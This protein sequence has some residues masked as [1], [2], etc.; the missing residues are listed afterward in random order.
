M[1]YSLIQ[2][3]G[4]MQ[5]TPVWVGDLG[6]RPKDL[7]FKFRGHTPLYSISV[8]N[9]FFKETSL[10]PTPNW[11]RFDLRTCNSFICIT[12]GLMKVRPT[13]Y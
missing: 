6:T 3:Q 13:Q 2:V 4:F 1:R 10:P 12:D 5:F 11:D 7:F 8:S 9:M